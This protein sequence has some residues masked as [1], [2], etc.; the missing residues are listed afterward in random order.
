MGMTLTH[1]KIRS[2]KGRYVVSKYSFEDI[3]IDFELANWGKPTIARIR[4]IGT[5][6]LAYTQY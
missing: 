4:K 6:N 1:L 2:I 3:E 5:L